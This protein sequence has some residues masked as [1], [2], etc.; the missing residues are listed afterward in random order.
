MAKK[1]DLPAIYEYQVAACEAFF[2]EQLPLDVIKPLSKE[3]IP[4]TLLKYKGSVFDI[5]GF[6]AQQVVG[7][8]SYIVNARDEF[9]KKNTFY[10]LIKGKQENVDFEEVFKLQAEPTTVQPGNGIVFLRPKGK[11]LGSRRPAKSVRKPKWY[12]GSKLY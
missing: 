6:D 12:V 4:T 10:L 9:Q 1:I 11:K 3:E 8:L 2:T 5:T 7:I